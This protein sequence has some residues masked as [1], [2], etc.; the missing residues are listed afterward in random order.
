MNKGLDGRK[1]VIAGSR[2]TEEMSI[3]IEKQG[4]VPVL[5]P[6]QGTVFLAEQELESDIHHFINFG[7]DWTI[8]T[9]GIGL[10]TLI[11]MSEKM[12]VGEE[13][14]AC[15]H[16]A[17]VA[18]RGYKTFAALKKIGLTPSI[19]DDD[20]TNRG[21]IRKLESVDFHR[22]KVMVQLHG[23]K[24][25]ALISFL[26]KRGA[27]VMQ[28]LPY[29]HI[30]PQRD[31]VQKL[32]TELKQNKIDAIC[33]TTAIQVRS[34]FSFA[35]ETGQYEELMEAFKSQA[36]AVAVGKVTAEALS[37]EGIEEYLV[38]QNERMGA[39]IIE[40]SHHYQSERRPFQHE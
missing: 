8:F 35:K 20:G 5:R 17:N 11:D 12:G 9:T 22:K 14:L 21:L 32:C 38:P 31:T 13:F 30:P 39:M 18:S 24:A 1:I 26:E 2:K 7:A 10:T 16:Q 6:L 15:I 33:F 37:E 4:G 25:P 3:L 28:L 19:V 34:L 29:R 36:L 27:E 23:E 40:L